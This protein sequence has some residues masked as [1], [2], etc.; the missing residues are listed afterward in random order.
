MKFQ[1]QNERLTCSRTG[2]TGTIGSTVGASMQTALRRAAGSR[3]SVVGIP[4]PASGDFEASSA[5]GTA[6][7][8]D[9]VKRRAQEC[10]QMKSV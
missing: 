1:A 7:L 5:E 3:M 4:Y 10:P 2:E 8:V 6:W 9:Y